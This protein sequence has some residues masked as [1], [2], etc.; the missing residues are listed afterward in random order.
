MA[1]TPS[2]MLALGTHAPDFHLPDTV[3]GQHMSLQD[4]KSDVATVIMFICNH[5]PYV[6]HIQDKLVEIARKYQQQEVQ[7]VAISANDAEHYPE[8]GPEKMREH[9][10]AKAFPF[11]YLYDESQ[12]TAKA[13]DAACTPDIYVFDSNLQL[14]YRGQFDDARPGNNMPVTGASLSQALDALLAGETISSEQ[15]PSTG[16]NIKWR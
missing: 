1:L 5:C 15:K 2:N 7:F 3:S 8:D 12:T 11:A 13:Y 9:A 4:F 14:V 10:K 16:C 6:I